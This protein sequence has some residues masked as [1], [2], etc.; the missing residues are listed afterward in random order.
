M[1]HVEQFSPGQKWHHR[2]K[3]KNVILS[4]SEGPAPPP[5]P[6]LFHVEHFSPGQKRH[7]RFNPKNVILSK[8]KDPLG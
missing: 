8:A 6:K 2:F 5:A 3:L 7:R 4:Q 1:F